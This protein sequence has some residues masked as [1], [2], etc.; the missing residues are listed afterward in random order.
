MLC[1]S[2]YPNKNRLDGEL[3]IEPID[4]NSGLRRARIAGEASKNDRG[5]LICAM[6]SPGNELTEG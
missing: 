4:H 3:E 2:D 6:Y 5:V 1:L